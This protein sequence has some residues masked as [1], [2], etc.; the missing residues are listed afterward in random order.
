MIQGIRRTLGRGPKGPGIPHLRLQGIIRPPNPGQP[1]SQSGLNLQ[2][3]ERP[4]ERIFRNKK[5]P[6]VALTVNSPGGSPAQSNILRK[7][8]GKGGARVERSGARR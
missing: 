2:L 4:L 1:R 5:A 3:L 7:C 8:V 6:A